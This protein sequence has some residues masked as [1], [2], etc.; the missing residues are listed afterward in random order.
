[1]YVM[2]VSVVVH[3]IYLFIIFYL[4]KFMLPSLFIFCFYCV[5]FSLLTYCNKPGRLVL[6]VMFL[7]L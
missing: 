4:L 3:F 2:V 1:M 5:D 6:N 7:L